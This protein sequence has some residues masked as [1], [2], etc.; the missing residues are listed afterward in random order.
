MVAVA[1]PECE[2]EDCKNPIEKQTEEGNCGLIEWK[3]HG[4]ITSGNVSLNF[5]IGDSL[6]QVKFLII[7]IPIQPLS[8]CGRGKRRWPSGGLLGWGSVPMATKE[9]DTEKEV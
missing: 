9:K 2:K 6:H 8:V 7:S 1:Y 5:N 3:L 4:R